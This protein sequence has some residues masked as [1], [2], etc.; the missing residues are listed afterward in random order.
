MNS[1][2]AIILVIVTSLS[3]VTAHALANTENEFADTVIVN[4]AVYTADPNAPYAQAVAIIDGLIARVGT[5][6][7][8]ATMV[9]EQTNVIDA[10]GKL[11]LPGFIDNHN[12]VFE[13]ASDAGGNCEL[14]P[15]AA[16]AKQ[17]PYLEF[18]RENAEPGEWII[19]WG[20]TIDETLDE[21]SELTP[22]Q[23]ID[24]V[25]DAQPV[26][27]M[28]QTSHSMWVNSVALALAGIDS[29]SADPQ[30]GK[31][32]RDDN[33]GELIGILIDNAGDIVMEQAW[34]SLKNKFSNS[35]DGLLTGLAESA[36]HGITTIGDGR[37]YWK[38][39]W[40]EVWKAAELNHD[41]TAR[42]SLRPWIYP[43]L[44][45]PEQLNFLQKVLTPKIDSLLIV[46]QVK[47]YSD[48]ILINGSAKLL[49]PYQFTYFPDTPYGFNY[50]PEKQMVFWLT[51]LNKIGYGAHIHAIG[52]GA[53]NE[54]LNAIE[55]A[56]QSGSTRAY[57]M[58]HI[59][60]V[61]PKD[62]NRFRSLGVDADYQIG[63]DYVGY[64]E[65]DWARPFIGKK[66]AHQLMP[67]RK[68]YDSG[69]NVTLSSDWNVNP[70]SPLASIANAIRLKQDG[71]PSLEVAIDA[72]TLNAAKALGLSTITGS[73]T[74]GKSAD[75]VVLNQN[76]LT[77]KPSDIIRTKV[78]YTMLRGKIVFSEP[79][80]QTH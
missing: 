21:T 35:Y 6:Q 27:I 33:T 73:I 45:P 60:M 11:V 68:L 61:A 24:S 32:M 67:L 13:A 44:A 15:A 39:G 40:Y 70:L 77:A 36:R 34:N 8:I 62:I 12:H 20:H 10:N 18:C 56:R 23:V 1:R 53:V 63:A 22:L 41:L 49:S 58:T 72:Y 37:L 74:V 17:L 48:G 65:H 78:I 55:H 30:G 16:P 5:N 3:C 29:Q 4:S 31:I 2:S 14:L 57:T 59:E 51:A 50:I 79:S 75:L 46:N 80:R 19:G 71:L 9:N 47:L 38:R 69:A 66:R 28:E 43:H 52:D 64:A 42:V 26:I 25:F 76:I 54:T 7:D